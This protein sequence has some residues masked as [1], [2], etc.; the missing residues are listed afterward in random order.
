M[1]LKK[2]VKE[3]F[4]QVR[5][6][7][8]S[9]WSAATAYF[10]IFS[11][12]PL[13]V[14]IAAIAGTFLREEIIRKRIV[15]QIA[16]FFGTDIASFIQ[17]IMQNAADLP[18]NIPALILSLLLLFF[19]ASGV[20]EHIRKT[21]SDMWKEK[22]KRKTGI[23]QLIIYR[24]I[25]VL[26]TVVISILFILSLA[27][28]SVLT[29]GFDFI[30]EIIEYPWL[31]TEIANFILLFISS[32][33]IFTLMY[34]SLIGTKILLSQTIIGSAVAAL[35]F[36]IGQTTISIYL[37]LVG[38]QTLFGAAS[39][40]IALLVLTYYSAYFFFIGAEVVKLQY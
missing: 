18:Q 26:L 5:K 25:A 3:V 31:L 2:L 24:F 28:N 10:A 34:L 9:R 39:S 32:T 22:R 38:I 6:N 40:V 21:I 8:I 17:S 11:L 37:N 16:I 4:L 35:L 15:W 27:V 36:S 14:L 23:K 1:S 29:A 20:F 12:P 13:I 30:S 33:L 19:G 7:N